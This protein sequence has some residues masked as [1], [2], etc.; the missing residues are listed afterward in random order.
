MPPV[1][2]AGLLAVRGNFSVT[3]MCG[4]SAHAFQCAD[5]GI[6]ASTR[7]FASCIT[8]TRFARLPRVRKGCDCPVASARRTSAAYVF[9][10][11]RM[12]TGYVPSSR[13]SQGT[14]VVASK[15]LVR[16]GEG[17]H[18][19]FGCF[20]DGAPALLS[21][22]PQEQPDLATDRIPVQGAFSS[23]LQPARHGQTH[24]R[25]ADHCAARASS[26]F[27][28]RTAMIPSAAGST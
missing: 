1:G 20:A 9:C 8:E 6:T 10:S 3:G 7:E 22:R 21:C 18:V 13:R 27:K 17:T 28:M 2:R 11:G 23:G 24:A 14:A 19:R 12:C 16:A 26:Q 4:L 5:G 15:Q 25:L